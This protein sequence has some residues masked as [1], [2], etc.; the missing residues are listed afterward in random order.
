M[1]GVERVGDQIEDLLARLRSQGAR[2]AEDGEALVRLLVGLYG[3]GLT[4]IVAALHGGGATGEDILAKLSSDPLVESLLLLHDLHPLD[5]DARILRALELLRPH[6]GSHAGRLRFLGVTDGVAR[7]RLE[8]GGHGCPSSVE[9]VR[10]AIEAAVTGAAPEV[11]EVMVEG[12]TGP[13]E[14]PLLQIAPR[15]GSVVRS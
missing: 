8:G 2:A 7:L 10:R 12:M 15:P 9:T 5:V 14:L 11:G 3:D 4:R 1:T 6:L 13:A